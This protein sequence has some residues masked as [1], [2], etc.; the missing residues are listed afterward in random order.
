[1]WTRQRAISPPFSRPARGARPAGGFTLIELLVVMG[2]IAVISSVLLVAVGRARRQAGILAMKSNF[3][4][5]SAAME[6][7]LED[8]RDYPKCGFAQTDF[9]TPTQTFSA[10][11][12][13]VTSPQDKYRP[14]P[15][16]VDGSLAMALLGPGPAGLTINQ[17]GTVG[18]ASG[19]PNA[20]MDGADGPGFRSR[21]EVWGTSTT[22]TILSAGATTVT[23]TQ[24]IS[25]TPL[26]SVNALPTTNYVPASG[27][28][29]FTAISIGGE[30]SPDAHIPITSW[31]SSNQITLAM[32]VQQSYVAGTAVS[33]LAPAGKTWGPY[34]P[35]DKFKVGYI[36]GNFNA[37]GINIGNAALPLVPVLMDNWGNQI[38]YFVA[39]NSYA[40]HVTETNALSPSAS[41][42]ITMTNATALVGPLIGAVSGN[43]TAYRYNTI[44]ESPTAVGGAVTGP[45]V[46]WDGAANYY[47][48]TSSSAG[49]SALSNGIYVT[50]ITTGQIEGILTM[51]GDNQWGSS[52]E[53]E[54]TAPNNAINPTLNEKLAV[55]TPYFFISA[56]PLGAFEDVQA[57]MTANP[58]L[59][60]ADIMAKTSNIYSFP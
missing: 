20:D 53:P 6:N 10:P 32:P 18:G 58:N 38:L 17:N 39:Y 26:G 9:Y 55:T 35:A 29:P 1:M 60:P 42:T 27:P 51:L 49:G 13:T 59:R 19:Y 33:L 23:L 21:F 57:D 34:L 30:G 28:P 8:F 14:D 44:L 40:N 15:P 54:K 11:L 48:S 46:F 22:T 37:P 56:G 45:A 41:P 12:N 47:A 3:Q 7:Y 4:M 2:I 50:K 16:R 25:G 5:I 31:T 36:S 52:T 24:P 43:S